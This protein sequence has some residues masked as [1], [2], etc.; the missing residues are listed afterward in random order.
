MSVPH[1]AVLLE[2]ITCEGTVLSVRTFYMLARRG[3]VYNG[4]I[5]L[6]SQQQLRDIPGFGDVAMR[7]LRQYINRRFTLRPQSM[8]MKARVNSFYGD[9]WHAPLSCI[10]LVVPVSNSQITKLAKANIRL[11]KDMKGVTPEQ[12]AAIFGSE[13]TPKSPTVTEIYGGIQRF[14]EL[15]GA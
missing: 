15:M 9:V 8:S 1:R 6:R 11:V 7:N 14:L 13:C 2:E 3:M 5:A 10:S 4:D 12:V